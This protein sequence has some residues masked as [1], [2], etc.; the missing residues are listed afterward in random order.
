MRRTCTDRRNKLYAAADA[1]AKSAA[2][3]RLRNPASDLQAFANRE[4]VV[5]GLGPVVSCGST[6]GTSVCVGPPT[7]GPFT[8]NVNFVEAIVSEQST[9]TFFGKVLGW[10]TGSPGARA[11]AGVSNPAYCLIV[12]ED[13]E[14]GNT[15][16]S[17][18]LFVLNGC[19]AAVGGNLH[20]NN[21]NSCI[22]GVPEP[23]VDVGT[24]TG[25]CSDFGVLTTGSA[26][27]A[28]PLINLPAFANP[29]P[30]PC[31]VAVPDGGGG[32]DPGC[33]TTIP[34]SVTTL[35]PGEYYIKNTWNIA[36][37]VANG[38]FVY[39]AGPN[40]R[41]HAANNDALN[42]TAMSTPATYSGTTYN[43]IAIFSERGNI[44]NFDAG[45]FFTLTLN[46]AI[47]MP[48]VDVVFGNHLR[49]ANS[50]C[51][52]FIAKSLDV[53]NGASNWSTGNCAA[54]FGNALFLSIAVTE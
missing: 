2:F 42:I 53:N 34:T 51:A 43:G 52:L 21:P 37:T 8:G 22:S 23:P 16:P 38:V 27:P 4:V 46:G 29:Y 41:I 47:Y 35:R 9:A 14:V 30:G 15:C 33:Y 7:S 28:D 36:N 40:G 12:M 45:N 11:V 54:L 44:E 17:S 48:S 26:A 5:M 13:M 19:G 31:G 25:T 18:P 49:L 20:G 3:A 32:I 24:C 10:A 50:N 1:A 39:L 6:G